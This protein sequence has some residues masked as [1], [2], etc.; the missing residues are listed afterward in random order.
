MSSLIILGLI[1]LTEFSLHYMTFSNFFANLVIFDWI[2]DIL[3]LTVLDAAYC[4]ILSNR[5]LWVFFFFW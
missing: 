4:C 5:V 2:P 3:N 1:L